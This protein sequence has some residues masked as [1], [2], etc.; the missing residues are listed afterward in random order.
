MTPRELRIGID[1]SSWRNGR[2]YGRVT[3]ELT[4]AMVAACPQDEFLLFVD[5]PSLEMVGLV[6][7][8]V[9]VVTVPQNVAPSRAAAAESYRSPRD[10]L[11]FTR[12][13]SDVQ[14]DVFFSP[15][16][17]TYFPL[18]PGLRSVV[19]I[20]DAIAERFPELTLPTPRARLFW[21]AKVRLAIWQANLVLTVSDYSA[22]DLV[23]VHGINPTRIRTITEAPSPAYRPSESRAQIADVAREAGLP[24]GA[25]W[26]LFVGGFNPHKHIDVIVRALAA[27][28]ADQGDAPLHLVLVGDQQLDVFYSEVGRIRTAIAQEGMESFVHWAGHVPDERLRHLH[29]GAFALVLPSAC[30]GFGL[31]AVEAAACGTPVIAT[32]ESPLPELLRG[33]GLFVEPGEQAS[34]EAALRHLLANE[35]TRRR[36]GEVARQRAIALRWDRAAALAMEAIREAAA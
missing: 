25:R 1:A 4:A 31:P 15:T 3:R 27:T 11:R 19:T 28:R 35:G 12:A 9:R 14:M 5:Q 6:A 16:V 32:R 34:L 23:S 2:G 26:V 13:V 29:T 21:H 18:P 30:E 17:Y 10:M 36:M 33:G 22:R 7:P 24:A 20:H 8:N